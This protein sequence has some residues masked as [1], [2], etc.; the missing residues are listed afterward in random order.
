MGAHPAL[1]TRCGPQAIQPPTLGLLNLLAIC[2]DLPAQK[3]SRNPSWLIMAVHEE[4]A[5]GRDTAGHPI[6]ERAPSRRQGNVR[7]RSDETRQEVGG[8]AAQAHPPAFG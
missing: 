1:A 6:A 2:E 8:N 3:Q 7:Q 4:E 5:T